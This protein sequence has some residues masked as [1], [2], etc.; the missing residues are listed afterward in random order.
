MKAVLKFLR[1]A[2]NHK[3][4]IFLNFIFNLLYVVFQL[5]TLMMIMPVLRCLFAKDGA[6]AQ[7]L[8]SKN[9]GVGQWFSDQYQSFI[10]WFG[11]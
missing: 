5:V 6:N 11:T 7:A 3:R 10:T 9:Y 8:S 1:Y 4:L 2:G